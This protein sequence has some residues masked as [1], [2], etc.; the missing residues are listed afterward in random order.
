VLRNPKPALPGPQLVEDQIS[1][2]HYQVSFEVFTK[3]IVVIGSGIT[4]Y[5]TCFKED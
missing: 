4:R 3:L 1:W 2:L 5:D